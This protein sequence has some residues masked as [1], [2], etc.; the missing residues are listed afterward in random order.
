MPISLKPTSR[1]SFFWIC[2]FFWSQSVIFG[3]A[4]NLTSFPFLINFPTCSIIIAASLLLLCPHLPKSIVL[5]C[6]GLW[7][8]K[9]YR[10]SAWCG[11]LLIALAKSGFAENVPETMFAWTAREKKKKKKSGDSACKP[12]RM[13]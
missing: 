13:Q 7:L 10:I 6:C 12:A 9:G 2:F 8:Y 4:E 1:F 3:S 11:C 5:S